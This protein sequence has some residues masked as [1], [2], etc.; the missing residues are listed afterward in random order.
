MIR[1]VDIRNQGTGYRFAFF[2]TA[3][4]QFVDLGGEEVFDSFND[5]NYHRNPERPHENKFLDRL[6]SLC[7]DWTKDG[8]ED[9]LE[10]WYEED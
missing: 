4:N 2:D 7:P 8:Q 9:D 10:K 3:I 1:F 6:Q 5:L